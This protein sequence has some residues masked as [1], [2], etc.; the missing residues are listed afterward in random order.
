VIILF[1]FGRFESWNLKAIISYMF[2]RFLSIS[3]LFD[4]TV[5]R[6][7]GHFELPTIPK[8]TVLALELGYCPIGVSSVF[9]DTVRFASLCVTVLNSVIK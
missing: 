5:L 4:L 3:K 7:Y 1:A 6:T 8:I 2:I 9:T